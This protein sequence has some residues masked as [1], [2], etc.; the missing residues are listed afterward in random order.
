M[1]NSFPN[2][3]FPVPPNPYPWLSVPGYQKKRKKDEKEFTT[4]VLE[5]V[6]I[7]SEQDFEKCELLTIYMWGQL[8]LKKSPT[9][10]LTK[11]K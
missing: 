2:D 9:V 3:F 8:T 1:L 6:E 10:I 7:L 5:K 4:S 11:I